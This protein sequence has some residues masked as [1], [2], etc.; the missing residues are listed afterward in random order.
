MFRRVTVR[1]PARLVDAIRPLGRRACAAPV[2]GKKYR[3]FPVRRL[4]RGLFDE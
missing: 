1:F 4:Q 2:K 3:C